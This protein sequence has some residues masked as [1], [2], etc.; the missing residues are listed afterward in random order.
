MI[1][2]FD[3]DLNTDLT[4]GDCL[5]GTVKFKNADPDKYENSDYGI[6]FEACLQLPLANGEWSKNFILGI[7]N[8]SSVYADNRK[9]VCQFQVKIQQVD[10]IKLQ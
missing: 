5:F 3:T 2:I 7:D 6:G 10:Q 1:K 8:S 4:L 9:K